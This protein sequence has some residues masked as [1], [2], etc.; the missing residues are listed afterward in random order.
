[1][2]LVAATRDSRAVDIMLSIQD[3][4]IDGCH[5]LF[6]AGSVGDKAFSSLLFRRN[7]GIKLSG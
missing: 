7:G 1:M 5:A 3:G 6:V 4:R 2:N